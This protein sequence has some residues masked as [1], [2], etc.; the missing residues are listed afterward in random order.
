MANNKALVTLAVGDN[1]VNSWRRF[2]YPSWRRYAEKYSYDIVLVD[3]LLDTGRLG[4]SRSPSWQRLL[5]CKH[6]VVRKYEQVV[7][8]DADIVINSCIAPCIV[9][10][11]NAVRD[12]NKTIGVVTDRGVGPENAALSL[13][14]EMRQKKISQ[15]LNQGLTWKDVY[16]LNG[17][18]TDLQYGF[19][20]GVMVLNPAMHAEI[21]D[22]VYENYQQTPH[23]WLEAVPLAFHL[24]SNKL[25]HDI[26]AP[27]NV[28]AAQVFYEHYPFLLNG[29]L[30]GEPLIRQVVATML[31]NSYFLHFLGGGVVRQ[32]MEFAESACTGGP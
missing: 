8:A 26:P 29:S 21:L 20:A 32:A 25:V 31:E 7:W 22:T 12:N 23:S 27:F 19:N 11:S 15:T 3:S 10:V 5:V 28:N 30:G 4:V 14:V 18:V 16:R 17:L 9:S 13:A 1:Y 6:P 24:L 2:C